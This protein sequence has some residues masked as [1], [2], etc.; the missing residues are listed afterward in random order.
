MSMTSKLFFLIFVTFIIVL[1]AN[2]YVEDKLFDSVSN[3][4]LFTK[5]DSGYTIVDMNMT[6]NKNFILIANADGKTE[7]YVV[8]SA[9]YTKAYQMWKES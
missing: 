2:S 5:L 9:D 7:K 1:F 6:A 3:T 4:E 8:N